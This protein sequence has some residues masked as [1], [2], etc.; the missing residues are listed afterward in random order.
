VQKPFGPLQITPEVGPP[1]A[2]SP[3]T[4]SQPH[5]PVAGRHCGCAPPH[6]V[7]FVAE[8]SVHEPAS[9]PAAWQAGRAGSAQVGAPSPAHGTQ[10][11]VAGEHTG[12]A[13]PQSA[14]EMHPTHT[15]PPPVVSQS[16]VAAAHRLVSVGVQT[17]HAPVLRQTG[18]FGSQSALSTQPRH[19]RVFASHTGRTPAQSAPEAHSTQALV[20]GSHTLPAAAHA[21]GLPA[22]QATHRPPAPQTGVEPPQSVSATHGRQVWVVASHAGVA[23]LQSALARHD[24]HVPAPVSQSGVAPVHAVLFVAEHTP[25]AP[26]G[27][28]AGFAPPHSPSP[29]Q[30]RHSWVVPSHTGAVAPGHWLLARHPSQV[31]VA[32][33]HTGVEPAHAAAFVAEH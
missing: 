29:T 4:P 3:A 23:P 18:N 27:W 6:N 8:H 31:P 13:P 32:V 2:A 24:T 17:A 1:Q 26:P 33:A 5:W 12:V 11:C 21:P 25:H 16:G 22:A 30:P 7:A 10:A 28:H 19:V 14:L 9:G 15:P 20:V